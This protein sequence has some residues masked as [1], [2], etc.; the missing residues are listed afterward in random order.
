MSVFQLHPAGPTPSI[1]YL[2]LQTICRRS[3]MVVAL[4]ATSLV[5]GCEEPT[6]GVGI[7]GIDHLPEYMSVSQFY[8]D[9]YSAFQAG[10]GASTV[11]CASLPSRWRP[12]LS[13][14]VRWHVTNWRDCDWT[15][16][17]RRV[18]VERY[19]EPGRLW[20]HFMADGAVRV[21]SSGPGP[22]NSAYPGPHDPIPSKDP[23]D[24]Y[25]WDERCNARFK[26]D[27]PRLVEDSE[28]HES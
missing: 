15:L 21:I 14:E 1:P 20:V 23:W 19:D 10:T 27:E 13:A 24:K 5:A 8:V 28:G 18:P 16:H 7:T 2:S 3:G 12:N 22:G 25:P 6:T 9:G 17:V 26:G 11:C 4:L